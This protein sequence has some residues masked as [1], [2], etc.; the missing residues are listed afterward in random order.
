[1]IPNVP[2]LTTAAL[3]ISSSR[4]SSAPSF[5]AKSVVEHGLGGPLDPQRAA[6]AGGDVQADDEVRH[7]AVV[8]LRAVR[9]PGDRA[10]DRL[11]VAD[12]GRLQRPLVGVVARRQLQVGVELGDLQPGL[13]EHDARAVRG[14]VGV[15]EVA[16]ADVV[17]AVEQLRVDQP[18]VGDVDLRQ[19]PARADRE[20]PLARRRAP[21]GSAR[22]GCRRRGG[23]SRTRRAASR[24]GRRCRRRSARRPSSWCVTWTPFHGCGPRS[25]RVDH[26]LVSRASR[27]ATA[28]GSSAS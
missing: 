22:R 11:A 26:R 5:A 24:R 10:G 1:M 23:T 2:K 12:P 14:R 20:H 3:K 9:V 13:G 4:I 18:A 19:R 16:L 17:A 7:R 27:T 6:A 28:A 15:L 25:S 8:D 21:R